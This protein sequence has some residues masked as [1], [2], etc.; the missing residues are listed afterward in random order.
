MSQRLPPEGSSVHLLETLEPKGLSKIPRER[1]YCAG[2]LWKRRIRSRI[3][4]GHHDPA[5]DSQSKASQRKTF[6][7]FVY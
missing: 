1:G 6:H 3:Q 2:A 7:S 4:T 5:S